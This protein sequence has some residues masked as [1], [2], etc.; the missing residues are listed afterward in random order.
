MRETGQHSNVCRH[1]HDNTA[2]SGI[3]LPTLKV[4]RQ[5]KQ[6]DLMGSTRPSSALMLGDIGSWVI[7]RRDDLHQIYYT[8]AEINNFQKQCNLVRSTATR[9]SPVLI[10]EGISCWVIWRRDGLHEITKLRQKLIAS[11]KRVTWWYHPTRDQAWPS[12]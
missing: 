4:K 11:R 3:G 12:C 9:P 1:C 6:G 10:L 5:T 2:L 8:Y 7:W